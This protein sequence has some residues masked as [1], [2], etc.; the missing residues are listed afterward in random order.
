MADSKTLSVIA[1]VDPAL[2]YTRRLLFENFDLSKWFALGFT[3]F[4]ASLGQGGGFGPGLRGGGRSLSQDGGAAIL[5]GWIRDHLAL[6]LA[7]GGAILL[8]AL[9][10]GLLFAWLSSRGKF[11]FLDNLV[12][13]RAEVADP[14]ERFRAQGNALFLFRVAVG[15]AAM[16]LGL[17]VTGLGLL[18]AYPDIR[19][20]RFGP[21]SLVAFAAGLFLLLV[22]VLLTALLRLAVEDFAVPIVYRRGLSP[23]AA[24]RL[25]R[26]EMLAGNEGVF[27]LYV[28]ARLVIAL[29]AGVLV[30]I[31][32]CLTCCIAGLPYLSSVAFL[33]LIVF[34]RAYSLYF[35]AEFGPE[36]RFLPGEGSAP[37][38]PPQPPPPSE[39]PP[40]QPLPEGA[41][42]PAATPP[43]LNPSPEED[44]HGHN[45]DPSR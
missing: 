44:P 43:P 13:G 33:P 38:A 25:F 22:L 37:P 34:T 35:L 15:L 45:D 12:K 7:V 42:G 23:L 26:D 17:L 30:L 24:L 27:L 39:A 4:L 28:L 8:L 1:P 29:V 21:R 2:R 14:W 31:G 3:A 16:C 6:V 5:E 36:W 32:T 10:L 19:D 20:H 40:F 11:M 41:G 18:L 9:A